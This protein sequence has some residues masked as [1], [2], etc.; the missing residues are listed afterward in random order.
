[1]EIQLTAS[2]EE[3]GLPL[4]LPG[5]AGSWQV[6]AVPAPAPLLALLCLGTSR[7]FGVSDSVSESLSPQGSLLDVKTAGGSGSICS[8]M[9][10]WIS[11]LGAH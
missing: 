6:L 4:P 5:Q 9:K 8:N 11:F 3:L 10:C 2:R 7:D 1:M